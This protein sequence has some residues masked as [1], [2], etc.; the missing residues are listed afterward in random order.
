MP[1]SGYG[2]V[3]I[4]FVFKL[5]LVLIRIA[6]IHSSYIHTNKSQDKRGGLG[7]VHRVVTNG[8]FLTE[9]GLDM[10]TVPAHICVLLIVKE[11]DLIYHPEYPTRL[12]HKTQ[13]VSYD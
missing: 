6:Y 9:R 5:W 4:H 1:F 8:T 7:K 2:Y 10:S 13:L 12:Q 11:V 3:L